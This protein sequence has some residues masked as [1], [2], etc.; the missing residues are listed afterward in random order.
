MA[1]S[2]NLKPKPNL[3]NSNHIIFNVDS[4]Y[5]NA[6]NSFIQRLKT[7]GHVYAWF[8]LSY[9]IERFEQTG[10]SRFYPYFPNKLRTLLVEMFRF[11]I[12]TNEGHTFK[13]IR[14]AA[15][16]LNQY[17]LCINTKTVN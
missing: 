16:I 17:L 10:L 3:A 2:L 4:A 1:N 8:H 14:R 7:F 5:F 11:T 6:I 15:K 12:L 9:A 13:P